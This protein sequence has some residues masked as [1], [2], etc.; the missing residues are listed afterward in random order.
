MPRARPCNREEKRA[1]F[2]GLNIVRNV[3]VQCEQGSNWQI[4][5]TTLCS[6]Q[7]MAGDS[8]DRDPAFAVMPRKPRACLQRGQDDAEVVKL[9]ERPGVL[10]TIPIGFTVKLLQ[11]LVE[12]EFEKGRRHRRCVRPPML[13]V[14]VWCV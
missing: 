11:L 7:Q 1:F 12:I 2:D 10:T 6:Y 13:V 3:V 9:R 4:E 14:F 8:L 5:C